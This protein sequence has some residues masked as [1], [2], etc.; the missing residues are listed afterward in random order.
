[1]NSESKNSFPVNELGNPESSDKFNIKRF[2]NG[3]GIVP[4]SFLLARERFSGWNLSL[5]LA[6]Q[7]KLV[8]N[9]FYFKV[10]LRR[11]LRNTLRENARHKEVLQGFL[12]KK[13]YKHLISNLMHLINT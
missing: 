11:S 10:S 6:K 8:Y 9:N 1:M 4:G 7:S 12:C 5:S 2:A 3:L 13:Q